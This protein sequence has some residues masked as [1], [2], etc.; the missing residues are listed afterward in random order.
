ML[1]I[2]RI[3]M[4]QKIIPSELNV[5]TVL[6]QGIPTEQVTWTAATHFA[7]LILLITAVRFSLASRCLYCSDQTV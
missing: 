4:E 6:Q 5:P 3:D 7:V 1:Q 2:P